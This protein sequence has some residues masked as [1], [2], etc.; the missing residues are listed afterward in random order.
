VKTVPRPGHNQIIQT[1]AITVTVV[2]VGPSVTKGMIA[3]GGTDHQGY[4]NTADL[5]QSGHRRSC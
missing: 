5:I 2:A 1:I 3:P 4:F